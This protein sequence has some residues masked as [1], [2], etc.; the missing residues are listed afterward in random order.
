MLVANTRLVPTEIMQSILNNVD[1]EN[2]Y[3]FVS[4]KIIY[5]K[6]TKLK[7]DCIV[8][9]CVLNKEQ[10]N[11]PFYLKCLLYFIIKASLIIILIHEFNLSCIKTTSVVFIP[12]N[13]E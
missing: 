12:S 8:D 9:A 2:H 10:K 1:R 13:T 11:V 7:N 5:Q 6:L 3:I 4:L